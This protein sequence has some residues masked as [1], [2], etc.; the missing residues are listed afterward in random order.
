MQHEPNIHAPWCLDC[1]CQGY[2][3]LCFASDTSLMMRHPQCCTHLAFAGA[4]NTCLCYHHASLSALYAAGSLAWC[5]A[6]APSS[7]HIATAER[8]ALEQ[9]AE[10]GVC[11]VSQPEHGQQVCS[12]RSGHGACLVQGCGGPLPGTCHLIPLA[13]KGLESAQIGW[14]VSCG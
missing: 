12:G 8:F 6:C 9:Q 14:P 5:A 10:A 4:C 13:S 1:A 2:V 11:R 3:A 7:L